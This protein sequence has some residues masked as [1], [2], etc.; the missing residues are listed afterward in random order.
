MSSSTFLGAPGAA[1]VDTFNATTG[2]LT[3]QAW[4][5][6]PPAGHYSWE[7]KV[8]GGTVRLILWHDPT[9]GAAQGSRA[10]VLECSTAEAAALGLALGAGYPAGHSDGSVA[11]THNAPAAGFGP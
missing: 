1:L 8:N 3:G 2:A 11:L 7:V 10:F 4:S 6:T 5:A 9:G